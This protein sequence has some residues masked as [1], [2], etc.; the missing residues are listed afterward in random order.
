MNGGT[1]SRRGHAGSEKP[2]QKPSQKM[3]MTLQEGEALPCL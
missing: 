3:S 1:E 2:G